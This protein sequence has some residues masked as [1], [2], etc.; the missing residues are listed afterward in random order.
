[1]N[2][3]CWL[4]LMK[5]KKKKVA[6]VCFHSNPLQRNQKKI[7]QNALLFENWSYDP[8]IIIKHIFFNYQQQ[9]WTSPD[10]MSDVPVGF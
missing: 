5:K 6:E 8:D 9:A 2:V 10:Q 1:M 7:I 3:N 4:F